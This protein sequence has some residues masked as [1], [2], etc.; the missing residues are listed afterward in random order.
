MARS[1][2]DHRFASALLVVASAV[3]QPAVAV[4]APC[5]QPP[6]AAPITDPFRAP[7]CRWCPGNR[8][9]EYRTRPGTPVRA[10]AA[11]RVTFAGSVAGNRYVVVRHAD[12]QR[13]TYGNLATVDV[14]AG[15]VVV[16][17]SVVGVASRSTHFGLRR[18]DTYVDPTPYLGR[19]V[20]LARLIPV[21]GSPAAPPGPTRW[22]CAVAE[23]SRGHGA[24]LVGP[25]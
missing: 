9:I 14:T 11:G 13:A 19:P 5:W 12:G 16:A 15:D 24:N 7:D 2:R 6:V 25:R 20:T 10:V 22:R 3:V 1:R 18:G 23:K 21:D 4:A 8:G 17:R